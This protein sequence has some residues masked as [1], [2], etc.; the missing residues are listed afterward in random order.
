[1]TDLPSPPAR[2]TGD[3]D[4]VPWRTRRR[5]DE[6]LLR[7]TRTTVADLRLAGVVELA[8]VR[9]QVA[10]GR[11]RGIDLSGALAEAGVL[12]AWSAAELSLPAVP[13]TADAD[14]SR[15]WPPLARDRIRYFGEALAVVAGTDRY[16]AEDGCDAVTVTIE[17]LPACLDPREALGPDAPQLWD[18]GNLVADVTAGA[19]LDDVLQTAPV[20]VEARYREQFVLHTSLE[21]RAIAVR[22]DDDGG[23]TIWVSHQAQHIL[24]DALAEAFELEPRLVRVIVPETGG[25]FGG[26]SGTW[27]EYLVAVR[28]AIELG[29][30]VRW[31]EDRREALAAG[32][33]GPRAVAERPA[34]GRPGRTPARPRSG[35]RRRHR[36]L[37]RPGRHGAGHD[38]AGCLRVLQPDPGPSAHPD[39]LHHHRAHLGLSRRGPTGGGVPARTNHGR[40]REALRPRPGRTAA[41]EL[42]AAAGDAAHH[43]DRRGVRQR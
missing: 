35:H 32:P 39:G 10:H 9:S 19:E 3:G 40:P 2:A 15:P 11:L 21:A 27:P 41:P 36:R 30:P 23:L 29:R 42:S 38:V 5:E 12:G 4:A 14:T 28:L 25:A 20:V 43:A 31:S 7:G 13:G 22:P 1:M 17:E 37:P 33:A 18:A 6:R 24:R 26:K 16:T 34:R 8:F